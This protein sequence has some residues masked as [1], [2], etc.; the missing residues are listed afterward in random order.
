MIVDR[1]NSVLKFL[2]I[3]NLHLFGFCT[4]NRINGQ[5]TIQF[6]QPIQV[7]IS[8][9]AEALECFDAALLGQPRQELF[10]LRAFS[11]LKRGYFRRDF[12]QCHYLLAEL[13]S[14]TIYGL[15]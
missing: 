13:S 14:H 15:S 5:R 8:N 4:S 11:Q 7:C 6:R 10:C 2:K 3:L 1:I 9:F 12:A